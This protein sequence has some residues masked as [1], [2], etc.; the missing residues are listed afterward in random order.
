[1]NA[2]EAASGAA[3]TGPADT[4]TIDAL[5]RIK[6]TETEWEEKVA[7]ARREAEAGLKRLREETDARLA[8]ARAEAEAERT[9]TLEK[10]RAEADGEAAKI[11][12][13]GERAAQKAT[14]GA[15]KGVS[16]RKDEVLAVVLGGFQGE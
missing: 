9:R 12:A 7:L 11:V 4:A 14:E 1:M 5:K 8:A 10:S 16:A 3:A 13:E 2:S 15:D 6:L